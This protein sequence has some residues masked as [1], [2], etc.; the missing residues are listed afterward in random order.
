MNAPGSYKWWYLDA[1]SDDGTRGLT[2]ILFYGSV[3]SPSYAARLRRGEPALPEE[4]VAVNLALYENGRQKTWVMSEYG[5]EAWKGE[6]AIAESRLSGLKL[7]V[8]DRSAP[9]VASL[10]GAG[11]RVEGTVELEPLSAPMPEVFLDGGRQHRWQVIVPRGRVRVRFSRPGFEFEG[12][13]YHDLNQGDSRLEAAFSRWS[14]ARPI[15][16]S[17]TR[18]APPP[19]WRRA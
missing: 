10:V 4:H 16:W 11:A 9:F 12:V 14:W 19:S 8:C 2:A 6:V 18:A 1:L 5:R 3:F 13:G 15:S 17:R 7:A